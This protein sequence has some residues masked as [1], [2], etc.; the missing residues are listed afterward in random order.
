MVDF[1]EEP[2]F[3]SILGYG[4]NGRG[5]TTF[6][7][8]MPGPIALLDFNERGTLSLRG[9]GVKGWRIEE[10]EKIEQVYWYLHSGD[11]P[12]KSLVW[13]TGTQAADVAL[14]HVMGVAGEFDTDSGKLVTRQDWGNMSKEVKFWL[15]KFRNLEM[16]KMF[17]FQEKSLDEDDVEDGDS[18]VVPMISPAVRAVACAAVDIIAR[19]E[20]YD[21]KVVT[22]KG[23]KKKVEKVPTY[24]IRIGPDTRY[25]TKFRT[26]DGVKLPVKFIDDPSY[27][28]LMELYTT[29]NNI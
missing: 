9:K 5:K 13:D 23:D 14:A 16:H 27:D 22:G 10:W 29:I 12:F 1:D 6:A 25:Q 21:K 7:G 4:K 3:L 24:R 2:L 18:L 17:L 8:T 19:F 26:P 15:T 20:L 28:K 11:H